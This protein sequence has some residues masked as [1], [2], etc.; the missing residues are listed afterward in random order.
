MLHDRHEKQERQV[1][2]LRE[3]RYDGVEGVWRLNPHLDNGK[4]K[5][6]R[7]SASGRI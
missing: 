1:M 7:V 2:I 3:C 4:W 5:M 6:K